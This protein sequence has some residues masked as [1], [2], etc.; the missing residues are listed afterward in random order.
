MDNPD[1]LLSKLRARSPAGFAIA[2]HVQFTTPRYLLQ[3]YRK[4][5]IDY[6][7]AGSL[8]MQDPTV[9][10]AFANNGAVRWSDLKDQDTAGVLTAA[11]RFGLKYGVAV[12]LDDGG[13]KTMASFARDD[14]EMSELDIAGLS[15][16]LRALHNRTLGSMILAPDIHDTLRQMSI[17][18]THG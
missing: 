15:A 18:L 6:Y 11:A 10:W 1:Q 12:A 7:S 3:A 5:W 9:H 8:V 17:F 4:D 14:R 16:D 2:L 13:S